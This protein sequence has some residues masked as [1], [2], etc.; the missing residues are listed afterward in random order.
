MLLF[1]ILSYFG[2]KHYDKI[3][4]NIYIGN[5]N[6][7][8]NTD[9]IK[10]N[11]ISIIINCSKDIPFYYNHTVN[12]RI[13]VN[14]DLSTASIVLMTHY[15]K[16]LIPI[17]NNHLNKGEI[18]FI[19]CR[20]GMQRSATFLAG[21]LMYHYKLDKHAVITLI[22]NKRFVCFL[23]S[24]NFNISLDIYSNYLKHHY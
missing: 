4:N 16:H 8:Q 12:Y 1:D 19:H 22:K 18:L 9:F 10:N 7:A 17:I 2:Y 6:T 13:P 14:D 21:L 23:P 15:L 24:G 3:N 11:N 5:I 20:A